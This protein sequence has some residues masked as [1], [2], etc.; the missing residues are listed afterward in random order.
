MPKT[1]ICT[2]WGLYITYHKKCRITFLTLLQMHHMDALLHVKGTNVCFGRAKQMVGWFWHLVDK[3]ALS[4]GCWM[5]F[6]VIQTDKS[7]LPQF[8]ERVNSLMSPL[9][10]SVHR[11]T[12][13]ITVCKI[14]LM[15]PSIVSQDPELRTKIPTTFLEVSKD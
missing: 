8:T 12:L 5:H 2:V 11:H 9:V 10:F 15:A 3:T 14:I 7:A 1:A 13:F 6:T 4:C